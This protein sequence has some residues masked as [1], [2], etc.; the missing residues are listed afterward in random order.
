VC[1]T[2]GLHVPTG[3]PTKIAGQFGWAP[4]ETWASI[5]ASTEYTARAVARNGT[6]LGMAEDLAEF[7]R[8]APLRERPT[9]AHDA[10]EASDRPCRPQLTSR[11]EFSRI[12]EN[13]CARTYS[14]LAA[15]HSGGSVV[16]VQQGFR[17]VGPVAVSVSRH[18]KLSGQLARETVTRNG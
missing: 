6:P 2:E 15:A 11:Q 9:C 10:P 18:A 3:L 13:R 14:E 8:V 16:L 17:P 5:T 7:A 1:T 12:P 4:I